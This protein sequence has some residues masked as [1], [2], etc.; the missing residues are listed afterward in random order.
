[1]IKKKK[2]PPRIRRALD[3]F[4]TAVREHEF[5]GAQPKEDWDYIEKQY[6]KKK[7]RLE[8]VLR[9]YVERTC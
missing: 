7:Q 6:E 1:M 2:L 9:Q 5:M 4:E 8:D 3:G